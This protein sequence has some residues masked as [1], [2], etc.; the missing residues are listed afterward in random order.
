MPIGITKHPT[1]RCGDIMCGTS[2]CIAE[3]DK[4]CY[5]V[6]VCPEQMRLDDPIKRTPEAEALYQVECLKLDPITAYYEYLNIIKGGS[7]HGESI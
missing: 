6:S 7:I 3:K 4:M 1:A 5:S 2:T